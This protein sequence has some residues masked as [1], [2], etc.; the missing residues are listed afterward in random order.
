M[1]TFTHLGRQSNSVQS[2]VSVS[3]TPSAVPNT[4]TTSSM[5]G[6]ASLAHGF[7]V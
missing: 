1:R 4:T 2:E 5:Q 7:L 6:W 3:S